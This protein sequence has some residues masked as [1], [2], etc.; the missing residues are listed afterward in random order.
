M[1]YY[2]KAS[3]DDTETTREREH[4]QIAFNA[5]V[6]GIVL[7]ENNHDTLPI[8]P[9]PVALFGSGA[10][11]TIKGGTGSGE[12]N[13]RGSVTIAEGLEAA[14]FTITS[15][16]WLDDHKRQY[17][18]KL[19]QFKKEQ[20]RKSRTLSIKNLM[21]AM[22]ESF[23]PP[24]GRDITKEDIR[25]SSTDTAI[26]VIARQAGEGMDRRIEKGE[27]AP[28][29]EEIAHLKQLTERYRKTIVIINTGSS[30]DLSALDAIKGIGALVYFC[31]QGMEGGNALAAVLSGRVSPSGRL[32]A[33][34]PIKYEDIPYAMDYS[35]LNGNRSDE[36]YRE[37]LYVGYR[38][39]DSFRVQPRYCFG[40]GLSY[41]R[42]DIRLTGA[43]NQ[44]SHVTLEVE[45]ANLGDRSAKEVVQ[46]YVSCPADKRH[47]EAQQLAAYGKT[48][49][50][51]PGG[52]ETL[53]IRFDLCD[54]AAYDESESA[55]VLDPGD[56]IIHIGHSS[57]RN[58]PAALIHLDQTS[59]VSRHKPVLPLNRHF[60][61]LKSE[62]RRPSSGS[63]Q[64]EGQQQD[65][66]NDLIRLQLRNNE[67]R[68]VEPRY[69]LP[70]MDPDPR[71]DALMNRL[72]VRDMIDI[73][74]GAGM[75]IN[76]NRIDVPGSVGN[77][78]SK[79][80][81]KG[82][83]NVA[84]CDGPAGLRLVREAGV[85]KAGNTKPYALPLSFFESLPKWVRRLITANRNKTKPVYQFTTA[86]PV[87]TALAQ[88]WNTAL[89]ERVGQAVGR[90]MK[91][92]GVTFW[93][94]PALNIQRNPLCGRNFEYFSED[95]LLSGKSAAA[96]VRGVQ[97]HGGLYATIKHFLCNNQEDNRNQ[98]SSNV[99]ERT[100]REIYLKGFRIAV[101]EG[102]AAAV[103]TSYNRINGI[104][105]PESHDACTTILRDEWGFSGV[106]MT[107]WMS[108]G[109]G[110]A[111][112]AKAISAGNDLIMAGLPS[113]KNIIRKAL[114]R[115][116]LTIDALRRS[117]ARVVRSI[118][119]SQIAREVSLDQFER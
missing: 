54:L 87:G 59:V 9:G 45:V 23:L 5:A 113:D 102:G 94:A 16:D 64:A 26:Y 77:T 82:L 81:R 41:T 111:S 70:V 37:G 109:R 108:T 43:A 11:F 92:Y 2:T 105:A 12:V 51:V 7:L 61:E 80:Y 36:D 21:N 78:T 31:Q 97:S 99:H 58:R 28:T 112:A 4:R 3:S 30:L 100:L 91:E 52:L 18:E 39:F 22:G 29:A 14:G 56:Y 6:E 55:F 65:G 74:V 79:L 114:R 63:E 8:R 46:V 106:V 33:T 90:E 68:T 101:R 72:T 49:E 71:V 119:S 107:D 89:L 60:E 66:D 40:Y 10:C 34:W 15:R 50:L 25:K 117:C 17:H 73:V 32:T 67:I 48:A 19:A 85:L 75:F 116:D 62:R 110:R 35:Y 118:L 69:E 27:N 104:Y 13:E 98:V 83:I 57:R 53:E 20:A 96:L 93:L 38:Y 47:R 84:F 24:F 1:K 95:P 44:G 76:K 88:S 42:T 86:F 115:G 103:M